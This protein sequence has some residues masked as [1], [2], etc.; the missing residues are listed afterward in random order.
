MRD[1]GPYPIRIWDPIV[2][3]VP[4]DPPDPCI[5]FRSPPTAWSITRPT[6]VVA[7]DI[8]ALAACPAEFPTV[9]GEFVWGAAVEFPLA[10]FPLAG[11]D[12]AAIFARGQRGA[13]E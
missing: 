11:F 7:T 1:V 12:W 13:L 8:A 6:Y 5:R 3:L 10:G 4:P 9:R 2:H